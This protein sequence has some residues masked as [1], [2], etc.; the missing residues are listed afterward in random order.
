VRAVNCGHL[1]PR[2]LHDG[3]ASA[4]TLHRTSVPLGL[5]ELSGGARAAEWFGFPPG[6]ALLVLTDGVTEARDVTGAFYPFDERLGAWA[7]REPPQVLDALLADL[8]G[9]SGGV[10]RDDVAVLVL[11]RRSQL[12]RPLP[13]RPPRTPGGPGRD[14]IRELRLGGRTTLPHVSTQPLDE[15]P[16]ARHQPFEGVVRCAPGEPV[17]LRELPQ[18]T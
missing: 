11:S 18:H 17:H 6:A 2:L 9:F 12:R 8:D 15:D 16:L 3:Q 14:G 5:A 10:R 1:P 13:R 4:I 7:G